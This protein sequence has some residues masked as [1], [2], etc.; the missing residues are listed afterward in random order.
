MDATPTPT[1]TNT[2]NRTRRAFADLI[3]FR[4]RRSCSKGFERTRNY[5]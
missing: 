3:Y 5:G 2:I 4:V 1:M